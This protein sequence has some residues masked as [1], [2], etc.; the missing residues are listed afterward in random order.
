MEFKG[1]LKDY[2]KH[3]PDNSV[4]FKGE[5]LIIE[6][7]EEF[8]ERGVTVIN[9]TDIT[10]LG[11]FE[12]YILDD[13][14]ETD[15]TKAIHKFTMKLPSNI[16]MRPSHIDKTTRMIENNENDTVTKASF[17]DLIFLNDDTFIVTTSIVQSF[18][19]VDK[20][21]YMLLNGQIPKTVKYDEIAK[22][23]ADCAIING[24]G[25]LG[26][27]FNTLAMI[28]SNIVRD[29]NNLSD[30]FRLVYD[31][32]YAKGIYNCKM[33]RYM[34]IPRYISNFTAITGSDPRHSVTVAMERIHGEKG[35]DIKTP[36]E[37]M[38][39]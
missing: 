6:I 17:Y 23:W 7:P 14:N 33:L 5:K 26:S 11:I 13:I 39:K 20:F 3:M 31:K 38:I 15:V 27:D 24:S 37:E 22:I 9:Q 35:G 29:P 16:F 18:N 21:I 30:P 28:V 32:Y 25:T 2:L 8:V 12:A 4:V 34:D 36:V 1:I 19:T 10:T